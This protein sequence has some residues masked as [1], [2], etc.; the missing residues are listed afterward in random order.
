MYIYMYIYIYIYKYVIIQY[1]I[2]SVGAVY[3]KS[4]RIASSY[5]SL[6]FKLK[7]VVESKK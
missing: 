7:R 3:C 5:Q 1:N 4:S 6:T 2:I